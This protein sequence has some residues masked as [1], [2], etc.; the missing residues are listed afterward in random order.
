MVQTTIKEDMQ[1]L[2]VQC[3]N[4]NARPVA[5]TNLKKGNQVTTEMF[6]GTKNVIVRRG[7]YSEVWLTIGTTQSFHT[8]VTREI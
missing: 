5:H 6:K 4:W 3:M 7:E 8:G 1:G 2:F